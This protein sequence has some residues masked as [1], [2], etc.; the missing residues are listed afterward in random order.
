MVSITSSNEYEI[1]SVSGVDVVVYVEDIYAHGSEDGWR[2]SIDSSS[3]LTFT[4][5]P[6][7]ENNSAQFDI[8]TD[9]G[10]QGTVVSGDSCGN[11]NCE[12]ML[13]FS[14]S[15]SGDSKSIGPG[16]MESGDTVT[17][18]EDRILLAYGARSAPDNW[19]DALE[20]DEDI[21][22]E[23]TEGVDGPYCPG[24]RVSVSGEIV[25]NKLM[26]DAEGELIIRD[27]QG[28]DD[29]VEDI[30]VSTRRNYRLSET[31][32]VPEDA[33]G[34]DVHLISIEFDGEVLYE[35]YGD[36]GASE[37]DITIDNVDYESDAFETQELDIDVEVENSGSCS[38]EVKVVLGDKETDTK[39]IRSG[40]SQTYT[41]PIVAPDVDGRENI[42]YDIKAVVGDTTLSSTTIDIT[43]S[44]ASLDIDSFDTPNSVCPGESFEV[45]TT[46]INP[47]GASVSGDLTI[48]SEDFDTKQYGIS[49]LEEGHTEEFVGEYTVPTDLD[50]SYVRFYATLEKAGDLDVVTDEYD[51]IIELENSDLNIID[52]DVP[53]ETEPG[54]FTVDVEVEN[55]SVCGVDVLIECNSQSEELYIGSGR[56]ESVEFTEDIS[57]G[58]KDIDLSVEDL[59]V[60]EE[61]D[62]ATHTV[63]AINYAH[64][65]LDNEL[66]E[67]VNGHGENVDIEGQIVASDIDFEGQ[68]E[69]EFELAGGRQGDVFSGQIS[70]DVNSPTLIE[71]SNLR[72]INIGVTK[73]FTWVI[74]GE[75][76]D[77]SKSFKYG[78]RGIFALISDEDIEPD[79]ASTV[80]IAGPLGNVGALR[81]R[82][83]IDFRLLKK[84]LTTKSTTDMRR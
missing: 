80:V 76:E 10:K 77:R 15:F 4:I 17:F 45:A 72:F 75:V 8:Y 20:S 3:N 62:T 5:V 81:G 84:P 29:I 68:V 19:P 25:N 60:N 50:T 55:D 83:G 54:E 13:E 47:S 43:V 37:D 22:F 74:D 49:N 66:V 78:T 46:V 24:D 39:T 69:S 61:K 35:G 71:F 7:S 34:N 36:I 59:V 82:L 52:V 27:E 57:V 41:V 16:P 79:R 73:D 42:T 65:D 26:G 40:R 2:P 6:I 23:L 64:L 58:L 9:D 14:Y 32:R 12:Q 53:S 56:T 21:E 48:E 67:F 11:D 51:D 63:Q 18:E 28:G 31:I 44:E 33:S 30:T 70:G 38:G 1:M